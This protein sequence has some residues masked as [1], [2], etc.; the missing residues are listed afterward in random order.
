MANY[1]RAR[2]KLINAQLNKL[3]FAAKIKQEQYQE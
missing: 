1:Q 3:K 2:N